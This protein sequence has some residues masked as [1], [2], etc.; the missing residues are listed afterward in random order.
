MTNLAQVLKTLVAG[1]NLTINKL[2][3]RTGIGQPT[4]HRIGSGEIANPHVSSLIPIARYFGI[5]ID[6]LMGAKPLEQQI[7]TASYGI[8]QCG[9]SKVPI[10]DWEQIELWLNEKIQKSDK[11]V[12]DKLFTTDIPVSPATFALRIKDSTMQP[13]LPKGT[14][15]VIDPQITP[16]DRDLVLAQIGKHPPILRQLLIDGDKEYMKEFNSK[17]GMVLPKKQTTLY[18][19]YSTNQH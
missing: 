4:L 8:N 13:N 11:L 1:K 12:T 6:Q 7:Q 3:R 2:A 16:T 9:Y 15:I 5:S 18:W 10:L 14:T 17:H 19:R